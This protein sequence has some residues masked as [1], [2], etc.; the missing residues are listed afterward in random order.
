MITLLNNVLLPTEYL[1]ITLLLPLS[2]TYTLYTLKKSGHVYQKIQALAPVL[3]IMGVV[4]VLY[5]LNFLTPIYYLIEIG[6]LLFLLATVK[7]LTNSF[8]L[9]NT[10]LG[11]SFLHSFPAPTIV[12]SLFFS[13]KY[14]T[15]DHFLFLDKVILDTKPNELYY[16]GYS[17]L[18]LQKIQTFAIVLFLTAITA[19]LIINRF[20]SFIFL[21]KK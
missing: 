2:T 15:I 8:T 11:F 9:K 14:T 6:T 19:L 16:W 18:T 20:D 13:L 3:L 21:K 7:G 17:L 12:L 4:I 5:G 10:T 1:I